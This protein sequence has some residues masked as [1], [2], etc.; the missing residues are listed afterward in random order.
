MKTNLL[1]LA[2]LLALAGPASADQMFTWVN[3]DPA[4]VFSASLSL[5]DA[6]E[7]QWGGCFTQ[8]GAVNSWLFTV[9]LTDGGRAQYGGNGVV[10]SA[11]GE[12][13]A[14]ILDALDFACVL[15]GPVDIHL[16]ATSAEITYRLR[17]YWGETPVDREWTAAGSWQPVGQALGVASVHVAEGGSVAVMVVF[18]LLV[19][20]ARS[21]LYVVTKANPPPSEG[22]YEQA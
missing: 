8:P 21:R 18:G 12:V 7:G 2:A 4:S 17:G 6:T 5:S 15:N 3:A 1:L 13:T 20:A 19:L 16:L 14:G 10:W 9:P 22:V 11:S